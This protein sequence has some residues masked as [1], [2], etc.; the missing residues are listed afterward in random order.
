MHTLLNKRM[1]IPE[2]WV[3]A[4]LFSFKLLAVGGAAI[5]LI[6]YA[7]LPSNRTNGRSLD[8]A[9]FNASNDFYIMASSASVFYFLVFVV[10]LI[11]GVVLACVSPPN[12]HIEIGWPAA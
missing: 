8:M 6:W 4:F 2:A 10:L 5:F 11:V 1:E 9:W 12:G 7:L 3:A